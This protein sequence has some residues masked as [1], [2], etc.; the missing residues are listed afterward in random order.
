MA[1]GKEGEKDTE[2]NT[3]REKHTKREWVGQSRKQSYCRDSGRESILRNFR[4]F[5]LCYVLSIVKIMHICL[6]L[7]C[8]TVKKYLRQVIYFF[9]F[10]YKRGYLVHDSVGW[11]IGHLVK[12]SGC[13]QAWW[14]S[15][16]SWHE[17]TCRDLMAREE[18]RGKWRSAR[19]LF[20]TSSREK[21]W[22]KKLLQQAQ[23]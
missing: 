1:S 17:I 22:T 20:I 11:K 12:A 18:A 14:K 13:F 23:H 19:L 4:I 7:F 8:I 16:G 5:L 9:F 3:H 15:K 21:Q 6:I 10:S 2:R